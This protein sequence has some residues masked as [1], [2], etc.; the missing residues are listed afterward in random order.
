MINAPMKSVMQSF[1]DIDNWPSWSQLCTRANFLTKSEW[2]GNS[3]FLMS[4]SLDPLPITLTNI[5]TVTDP[6]NLPKGC[7]EWNA[8]KFGI[9]S[10]HF[11][12]LKE[13]QPNVTQIDS[14]ETI[15]GAT[16]FLF[17]PLGV[18][19]IIKYLNNKWVQDLKK[20]TEHAFQRTN[21]N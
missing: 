5:F 19:L 9:E 6:L 14:I 3:K 13:I 20:T 18:S 16:L 2:D 4:I 10:K 12:Q 17:I 7:I 11:W 8:K 1:Y 21:N 15:T